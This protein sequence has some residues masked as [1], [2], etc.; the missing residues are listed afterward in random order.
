M[1]EC[2]TASDGTMSKV[3]QE[4]TQGK[5]MQSEASQRNSVQTRRFR[6]WI[7]YQTEDG[8]KER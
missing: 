4:R 1:T 3:D 7:T 5:R 8:E 2:T 6:K